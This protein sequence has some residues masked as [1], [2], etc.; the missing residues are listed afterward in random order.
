MS[1]KPKVAFICTHNSCRSQMAEA[2]SKKLAADVF[3]AYSAGTEI[4]KVINPDAVRLIR[5]LYGV[6]MTATQRPK[7]LAELPAVDIVVTMG[8]GVQCPY[9]SC[10]YRENWGLG[11]PTGKAEADFIETAKLIEE[12]ING[13]KERILR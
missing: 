13:L 5:K 9:L 3:E 8:C 12:K 6:D 2:I 11:D 7:L 10:K 4:K 1:V